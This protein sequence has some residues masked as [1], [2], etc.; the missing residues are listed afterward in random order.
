MVINKYFTVSE[1]RDGGG[2]RGPLS[3]WLRQVENSLTSFYMGLELYTQCSPNKKEKITVDLEEKEEDVV[4]QQ[5]QYEIEMGEPKIQ[6]NKKNCAEVVSIR[7]NYRI[8]MQRMPPLEF[9]AATKHHSTS[10]SSRMCCRQ[11]VGPPVV[12][13]NRIKSATNTREC[14]NSGV[15]EQGRMI[16]HAHR[17][18][19]QAQHPFE[20]ELILCSW[21][22]QITQSY[23]GGS[24]T[25]ITYF[26]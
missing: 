20:I 22:P 4:L 2:V 1:V 23:S 12:W 5:C 7:E 15:Q 25:I 9:A 16:R 13:G 24:V 19:R 14:N 11:A 17:R 8:R 18:E 10:N 3:T 21:L 6:K 26:T